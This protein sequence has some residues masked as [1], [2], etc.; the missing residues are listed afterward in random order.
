MGTSEMTKPKG[1]PLDDRL[2]ANAMYNL[3]QLGCFVFLVGGPVGAQQRPAQ[4]GSEPLR[5]SEGIIDNDSTIDHKGD[6][7][8]RLAL[9]A[10]PGFKRE[11]EYGDVEGS[12]LATPRRQ[13]ENR[14]P[15]ALRDLVEQPLLPWKRSDTMHSLKK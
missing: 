14:W 12:G 8:R 5:S 3:S 11:V 6:A 13:V 10:A 9:R 2:Y 1:D 15:P 7:H 4:A